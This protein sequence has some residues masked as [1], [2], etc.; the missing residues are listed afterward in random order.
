ME[1]LETMIL[2]DGRGRLLKNAFG[3]AL[4]LSPGITVSLDEARK[5]SLVSLRDFRSVLSCLEV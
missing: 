4:G 5:Q 3:L 2:G 1:S